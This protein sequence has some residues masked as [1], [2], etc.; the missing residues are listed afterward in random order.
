MLLLVLESKGED[1]PREDIEVIQF[2][3]EGHHRT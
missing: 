1:I 3:P 2:A